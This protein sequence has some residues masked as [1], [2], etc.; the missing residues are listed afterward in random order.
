MTAQA[1]DCIAIGTPVEVVEEQAGK[2]YRITTK[3]E[4]QHYYYI[5]RIQTSPN[6]NAQNTYILTVKKGVVV[7]KQS[8]NESKAL[9]IQVH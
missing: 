6:G 8:S 2:P 9:N 3:K 5:E 1:F 4:M 7:D